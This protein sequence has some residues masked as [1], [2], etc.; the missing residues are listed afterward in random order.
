[1]ASVLRLLSA[2]VLAAGTVTIPVTIGFAPSAQAANC[3]PNPTVDTAA[4]SKPAQSST[5]ARTGPYETCSIV[6]TYAAGASVLL[7]C[8]TTNS[9]GNLWYRT[10]DIGSVFVYSGHFKSGVAS[11]L[12]TCP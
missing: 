9:L 10:A 8:K 3:S 5:P 11:K 6:K 1:M 12:S 7:T 4:I 2:G